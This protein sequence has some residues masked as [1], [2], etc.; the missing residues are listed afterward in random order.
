[1]RTSFTSLCF[2]LCTFASVRAVTIRKSLM[3]ESFL[4]L[5]VINMQMLNMSCPQTVMEEKWLCLAKVAG[6][7]VELFISLRENV[8]YCP[9]KRGWAKWTC[10]A[11]LAGAKFKKNFGGVH[12]KISSMA[13][14]L[15]SKSKPLIKKIKEKAGGIV[16]KLK[17]KVS[18]KK[19][20]GKVASGV[21]K[22]AK[23]AGKKA[24]FT[25]MVKVGAIGAAAKSGVRTEGKK[26]AFKRGK[27]GKRGFRKGRFRKGGFRK[28]GIGKKGVYDVKGSKLKDNGFTNMAKTG[29]DLSKSS[30][31]VS[32]ATDTNP[33]A[34]TMASTSS[35]NNSPYVTGP[36]NFGQ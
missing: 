20:S 32:A 11:R 22:Q 29:K 18:S 9:G 6:A 13:K 3:P 8:K 36:L 16:G 15:T 17:N 2:I 23:K 14:S 4:K 25:K 1:M 28:G 5:D 31:G 10:L 30:A 27:R 7:D 34:N 26:G 12:K 33:Y 19:D 35:V 21:K 24:K